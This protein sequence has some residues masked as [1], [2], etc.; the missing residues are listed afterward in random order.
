MLEDR[1]TMRARGCIARGCLRGVPRGQRALRGRPVRRAQAD[2]AGS[3]RG[4]PPSSQ[5]LREAR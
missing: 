1:P 4:L 5:R 2:L 3:Q